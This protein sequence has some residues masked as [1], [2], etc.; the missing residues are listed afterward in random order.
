MNGRE[1]I[2]SE[3]NSSRHA[4]WV[5][6]TVT[7]A[8]ISG[9]LALLVST[10]YFQRPVPHRGPL[11]EMPNKCPLPPGVEPPQLAS[12]APMSESRIFA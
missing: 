7:I 11:F 8:S 4:L 5:S 2:H 12:V 6:L 3:G 1:S 9:A 10:H